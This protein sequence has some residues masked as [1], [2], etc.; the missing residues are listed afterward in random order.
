MYDINR[1]TAYDTLVSIEKNGSYSNI[2]LNSLIKKNKAD[3]P[4]FVR[5]LTYGVLKNRYLLDFYL[6]KFIKKAELNDRIL[7]R[8]GI[9]Q[10]LFMNSVPVYAA[11]DTTV[12]LAKKLRHGKTAFINGVLRNFE[13]SM[14]NL[15]KAKRYSVKYSVENW[16]VDLLISQY[17]REMTEEILKASN[18]T[19]E[20][21]LR[22]NLKKTDVSSL[23][24]LL[25]GKGFNV[26]SSNFSKRAI[27]CD[28]SGILDT[29]EFRNGLFSVQD[30]SSVL[31]ADTL[32]EGYDG[33]KVTTIDTCAAPGG[34]T[35]AVKEILSDDSLTVACDVY[36]QKL[37][38]IEQS[39]ER[40]GLGNIITVKNDSR[41]CLTEY[42]GKADY[43]LCDVP[44]SGFGV[45]RRKPEIKYRKETD[46]EE[47]Y[48]IQRRI[49]EA[50]VNYLTDK[51]VLVYS[52]CTI[53]KKENEEQVKL[54]LDKYKDF[55][56]DKEIKLLPTEGT[57]GFYI[58]RI[59]RICR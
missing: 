27:I 12:E 42:M 14:D 44:C 55:E 26:R 50:S 57:D 38:L 31:C 8:M 17:G 1:K 2:E 54:F 25:A 21:S 29:E 4:A 18:A 59:K 28:G 45:F 22:V 32:L 15:P 33:R 48:D 30:E 7:L 5:E 3:N 58:A 35:L 16:I 46:L 6:E 20:L 56:L 37:S 43:V 49:L 41:E 24:E 53:N 39:K 9:Y 51:G 36:E 47:L 23:S 11:I 13:R 34:K 10:M 40:L 52:T 19:P